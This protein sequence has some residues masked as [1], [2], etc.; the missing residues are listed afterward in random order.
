VL[1]EC[2]WGFLFWGER[3]STRKTEKPTPARLSACRLID[4]SVTVEH[5]HAIFRVLATTA[6]E[7]N[8]RSTQSAALLLKYRFAV[9]KPAVDQSAKDLKKLRLF[10]PNNSAG[11]GQTR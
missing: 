9:P 2:T 8:T 11:P 3:M 1:I 10:L 6:M 4:N 5:W 7:G